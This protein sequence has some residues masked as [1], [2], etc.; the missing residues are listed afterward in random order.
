MTQ[1]ILDV[2][3][4]LWLWRIEYPDWRP[5]LGG[6][7]LDDVGGGVILIDPL[8]PPTMRRTSGLASRAPPTVVVI[9]N[10]ITYATSICS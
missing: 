3:P 4:G 5:R 6:G 2:A 10:R 8:A 9:L 7:Q 1:A